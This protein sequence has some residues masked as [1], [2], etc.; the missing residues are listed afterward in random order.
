MGSVALNV[1]TVGITCSARAP[2]LKAG[3][4]VAADWDQVALFMGGGDK[5]KLFP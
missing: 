2:L 1:G 3:V 5:L 4:S